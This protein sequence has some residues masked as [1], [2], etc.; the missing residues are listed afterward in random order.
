MANLRSKLRN[1]KIISSVIEF[2][3]PF[4]LKQKLLGPKT[5]MTI[6]DFYKNE[7]H[8]SLVFS[9]KLLKFMDYISLSRP[10]RYEIHQIR[11]CWMFKI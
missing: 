8:H 5:A 3:L 9:G 7:N 4:F 11:L 1:F 6:H 2:Y 10:Y